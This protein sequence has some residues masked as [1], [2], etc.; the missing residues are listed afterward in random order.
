MMAMLTRERANFL[1]QC[2]KQRRVRD[3]VRFLANPASTR[4][5][6]LRKQLYRILSPKRPQQPALPSPGSWNPGVTGHAIFN[7]RLPEGDTL[8]GVDALW[9][10][11]DQQLQGN[12]RLAGG[13]YRKLDPNHPGPFTD[14][15]DLHSYHRLYWAARYARASAFGHPSAQTALIRELGPW[16]DRG[17]EGD[18]IAM[19][20]YTV[21]ERITSLAEILFWAGET[22]LPG[23][24]V[25]RI[26][27][28]AARDAGHLAGHIEYALGI[29]N[30]VLNDARG[31]FAAA[32]LLPDRPDA[33]AW[34]RLAFEL[35]EKYFPLLVLADGTFAEGSS[36]YHVLL[37][38]TAL[39][40]CLAAQRN[41]REIPAELSR[42]VKGMFR[43]ANDLLRPDGSLPRF[44][45]NSPDRTIVDLWGLLASAYAHG[46]LEETPRHAAITPLTVYYGLPSTVGKT[47]AEPVAR[48][49][50]EGGFAFLRSADGTL[51][52]VAHGDP[53]QDGATHGDCGRGAF[54]LWWRGH[55]L[56]REPG[57]FWSPT[58]ARSAW[59]RSG[60]AQNVTCIDGLAPAVSQEDQRRLPA[61]YWKQPANTWQRLAGPALQFACNGFRRLG[62][63]V[64]LVRTW[65]FDPEGKP[66]FSERLTGAGSAGMESRLFLGEGEW[67]SLRPLAGRW[68]IGWS[69]GAGERVTLAVVAPQGVEVTLERTS[70]LSEYGV[71]Q[72]A[73]VLVL[74]GR[75]QLPCEWSVGC[76]VGAAKK[77]VFEAQAICV[78]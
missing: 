63:A 22:G 33:A 3:G 6:R 78:A 53:R 26:K 21:A 37:C 23:E 25:V 29:H 17:S 48:L 59:Y 11:I 5:H 73:Q 1:R 61:W 30:H 16:L 77:K 75:V 50:P 51:E 72:P 7:G 24:F 42:S 12:F 67:G 58:D 71:E 18:E 57:S 46:W 36:H 54:E 9:A 34:E 70:V 20:A 69:G 28:Q 14:A 43:Q 62:S 56:I 74:R 13:G 8:A 39:E 15:E 76:E 44:G 45:D 27:R 10:D 41:G 52:I 35:S 40:Y 47:S 68:E 19:A 65:S 60:A 55:V 31:L 64:G 66:A 38:R 4:V 32:A 2:W 49:Y